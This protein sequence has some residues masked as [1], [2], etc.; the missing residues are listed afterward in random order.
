MIV[1]DP[2]LP[3]ELRVVVIDELH[4]EINKYYIRPNDEVLLVCLGISSGRILRKL[5][6]SE[7][8]FLNLK[9]YFELV[10]IPRWD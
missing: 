1:L 10:K 6:S 3:D 2:G 4:P 5:W 7:T 8:L 9:T